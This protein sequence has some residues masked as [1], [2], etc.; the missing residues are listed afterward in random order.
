M[1]K[2]INLLVGTQDDILRVDQFIKKYEKDLSRSKIKNLILKKNLSI[3][4][5]LNDDPSKKIKIN[6][7]ISL[8]IPEP[9]EVN[10][11]PVSYTHLTLPTKA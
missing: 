5:K 2:I 1:K 6:D 11:K 3:N 8:I 9:E 10:L 4:N 7:K